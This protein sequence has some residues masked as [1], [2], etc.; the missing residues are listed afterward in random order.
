MKAEMI[1]PCGMNCRLC[2]GYIRK[3][4]QCF[5]CRGPDEGKPKSCVSC[6]IITCEKRIKNGWDTCAPCDKHCRRIKD[7]DKRYREKHHMSMIENLA[8]IRENGMDS[9]LQQQTERFTCPECGEILSVHRDA[10]PY[11]KTAIWGID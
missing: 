9:F 5:G 2:Y 10:C 3:R 11:C 4:N 8:Y 7:L 1:A 6:K